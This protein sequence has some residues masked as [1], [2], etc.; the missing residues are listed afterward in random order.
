MREPTGEKTFDE[1]SRMNDIIPN[2]RSGKASQHE[3]TVE[4]GSPKHAVFVHFA[5]ARLGKAI[6]AKVVVFEIDLG[7]QTSLKFFHLH[8]C[9]LTFEHRLLD[10]LANAFADLGNS[11]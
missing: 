9:D 4:I 11:A 8:Q 7:Q 5:T 6:Q 2:S 10:A 1:G 3:R